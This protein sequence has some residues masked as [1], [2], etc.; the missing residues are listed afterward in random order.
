MP[1]V[2]ARV[3]PLQHLVYFGPF[4]RLHQDVIAPGLADG[5]MELLL[6]TAGDADQKGIR[7]SRY[8]TKIMGELHPAHLWHGQVKEHGAGKLRA[9]SLESSLRAVRG[10]GPIACL[11]Q[12]N[13][14]CVYCEVVIV[15]DQNGSA[16]PPQHIHGNTAVLGRDFAGCLPNPMTSSAYESK[17]S[18]PVSNRSRLT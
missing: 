18:V 4:D 13:S 3:Q 16:R 14:E 17:T 7:H 1:L 11:V 8:R 15:Y 12:Q 6:R 5:P 9:R 2:A 10:Y